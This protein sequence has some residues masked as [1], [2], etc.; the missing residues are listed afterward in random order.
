MLTLFCVIS[1]VRQTVSSNCHATLSRSWTWT[2]CRRVLQRC[3]FQAL[4]RRVLCH[5]TVVLVVIHRVCFVMHDLRWYREF[6]YTDNY[7]SLYSSLAVL[8]M[9]IGIVWMPVQV[10]WAITITNIHDRQF[11]NVLPDVTKWRALWKNQICSTTMKP[12]KSPVKPVTR[13]KTCIVSFV[14]A[15]IFIAHF[16]MSFIFICSAFNLY[17]SSVCLHVSW[18]YH[19]YIFKSFISLDVVN[20]SQLKHRVE[21]ERL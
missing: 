21:C 5:W 2:I 18:Q 12:R 6:F 1:S 17:V 3:A 19:A 8:F 15:R 14:L 9:V 16:L 20:R 7:G 13:Q 11:F 10:T 4:C